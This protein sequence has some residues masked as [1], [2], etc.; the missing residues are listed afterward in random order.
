[1]AEPLRPASTPVFKRR[2]WLWIPA[3]ASATLA[4]TLAE[5]TAASALD[6]T[7]IIFASSGEPTQATNRVQAERRA[8]DDKAYER[9]GI[10]NV[11]GGD[12]LYAM[13]SQGATGSD[14]TK[15]FEKIPTGT[16]GFI[17]DRRGIVRAT[18]VAAGQFVHVYPV[19]FGPS[20]PALAGADETAE[21][22]MTVT[23][24]ITGEPAIKVAILA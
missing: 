21:D 11:T 8:G 7:R 16:T 14:G 24:A 6:I 1:M 22:A 18:N 4:P 13:N 17:A 5:A 3:I 2:N 9:I 19:E 12:M 15:W 10:T 20:F 23:F